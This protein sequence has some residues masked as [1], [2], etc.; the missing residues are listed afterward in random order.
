MIDDET[1][2][3]MTIDQLC[4]SV[5]VSPKEHVDRKIMLNCSAQ[6]AV[7]SL[8]ELAGPAD[9]TAVTAITQLARDLLSNPVIEEF[10]LR[11]VYRVVAYRLGAV[12]GDGEIGCES[13][14]H[15]AYFGCLR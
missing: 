12:F 11:Q 15:G 14:G 13:Q 9:E 6:D 3:G 4:A 8:L 7:D 1:Y 10:T 5:D 2:I